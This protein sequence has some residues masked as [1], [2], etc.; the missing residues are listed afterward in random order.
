VKT[1]AEQGESIETARARE[2][3][4]IDRLLPLSTEYLR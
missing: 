3:E 2:R 1:R 4:F